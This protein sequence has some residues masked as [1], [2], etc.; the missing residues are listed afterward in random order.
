[1]LKTLWTGTIYRLKGL[2]GTVNR[3]FYPKPHILSSQESLQKILDEK[4]SVA[5]FGDGEFNLIWGKNLGFQKADTTLAGRLAEVLDKPVN[6]LEIGLPE[7]FGDLSVYEKNSARFWKSYM[8]MYRGRIMHMLKSDR[9]YLNTNMTR[10][11]T[12][13]RD[14]K[15]VKTI[16]SLYKEI[17]KNRDVVFV[18]GELTRMGVGNDLFD[19]ASSVRRVLCPAENAWCRYDE[20]LKT[21]LDMNLKQDTLFVLAL[22]PAATVLAYDLAKAGYQALDLGHL[23]VQY[24]YSLRNA[25][26]KIALEGKYVNENIVGHENISDSIIDDAY[27]DSILARI[28]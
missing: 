13:Y 17:W 1:M 6:T 15:R 20:I 14:K 23:D 11:W 8:G 2:W 18:E 16:I 25:K 7:V 10:F 19:T 27:K 5:R 21:I 12:G 28:V 4:C 22:G 9:V 24:E 3:L 26:E